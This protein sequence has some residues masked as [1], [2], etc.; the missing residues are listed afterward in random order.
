MEEEKGTIIFYLKCML[1]LYFAFA[2]FMLVLISEDLVV[3]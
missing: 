3:L 2:V 1:D